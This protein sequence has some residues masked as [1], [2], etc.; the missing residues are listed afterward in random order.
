MARAAAFL[1]VV[2]ICGVVSGCDGDLPPRPAVQ[3]F[4]DAVCV[5]VVRCGAAASYQDCYG[6]CT[7]DSRNGSLLSVRPESGEIFAACL[8]QLDCPT[9]LNGPYDACWQRAQDQ[10]TFSPHLLTVCTAFSKYEFECGYW[11]PVEE[12]ESGLSIR[13]DTFLDSLAGCETK[14]TCA[15]GDACVKTH[16]GGGN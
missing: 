14:A 12:C 7:A 1:S 6:P 13:T 11:L 8:S 5:G 15:D 2:S 10:S 16:F 9:V 3:S 4:C